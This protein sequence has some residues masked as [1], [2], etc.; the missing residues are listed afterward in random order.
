[1]GLLNTYDLLDTYE[2]P[3]VVEPP[4][5]GRY[6]TPLN[7]VDQHFILNK[8]WEPS[9]DFN[10]YFD[11]Q[12]VTTNTSGR[13]LGTIDNDN[14][15]QVFYDGGSNQLK[16][17]LRI[18]GVSTFASGPVIDAEN[19]RKFNR[20]WFYRRG[21]TFGL[22]VN[23]QT[24]NEVTREVT[25]QDFKFI[26]FN[27]SNT[28]FQG[29]VANIF[30]EDLS[31]SSKNVTLPLDEDFAKAGASV[32]NSIK[33]NHEFV[34]VSSEAN[35]YSPRS[36]STLSFVSG[37]VRSTAINQFTFGVA[38]ALTNLT[39]GQTYFLDA[40]VK[41][42]NPSALV[43]IRVSDAVN[44]D[45]DAAN[46]ENANG[47]VGFVHTFVATATT[48]Y[49]GSIVTGHNANDYIEIV[50][51]SVKEFS[52]GS[53]FATAQNITESIFY[54]D[55]LDNG[56]YLSP[57]FKDGLTAE[58]FGTNTINTVDTDNLIIQGDGNVFFG[59]R[60]INALDI[61]ETYK[62]KGI[63]NIT[64]GA[65]KIQTPSTNALFGIVSQS[66]NFEFTAVSDNTTL[67]FVRNTGGQEIDAQIS[68]F[69]IQ[70]ILEVAVQAEPNTAPTVTI[71]GATSGTYQQAITLTANV[72]DADV[73]DTHTYLWEIVSGSGTLPVDVNTQSIVVTGGNNQAVENTVVRATVD[74]G[75]GG[76]A[77]DEHTISFAEQPDT[78]I[79][80]IT[81]IG[82]ASITINENDTY[83][84][85]GATASDNRDG[86][87]TNNIVVVN[88]VDAS[89]PATYTITYNVSDAAG[90]A[91][92]EVTRTVIVQEVDTTAPIITVS[93][94]A[95][96]TIT[97]GDALPTFNASTDDG[98][99]I[100]VSYLNGIEPDVNTV[101]RYEIYYDS[102]DAA[103]NVATT[104]TRVIIVEAIV[105][106]NLVI[107][108]IDS[109]ISEVN[110]L[111][112]TFSSGAAPFSATYAGQALSIDSQDA[113]SATISALDLRAFGD[114]SLLYNTNY[115]LVFTD[116]NTQSV[117]TSIV[118]TPTNQ[119]TEINTNTFPTSSVL[120]GSN[121]Q[122]GDYFY[123]QWTQNGNNQPIPANGD[124]EG[125]DL[126]AGETHTL[127]AALYTGGVWTTPASFNITPTL[128]DQV[129]LCTQRLYLNAQQYLVK[130]KQMPYEFT[131]Q[132]ADKP[133]ATYRAE[134]VDGAPTLAQMEASNALTA[135]ADVTGLSTHNVSDI[136]T[137]TETS[138][139]FSNQD[140]VC[141]I[142][143]GDGEFINFSDYV[144]SLSDVGTDLALYNAVADDV[145]MTESEYNSYA[146]IYTNN[147]IITP[148]IDSDVF[149]LVLKPLKTEVYGID[150]SEWVGTQEILSFVA[151]S[152]NTDVATVVSTSMSGNILLVRVAGVAQGVASIEFNYSTVSRQ[153]CFTGRVCVED[154]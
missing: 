32:S 151:S 103:G 13:I 53:N 51:F 17:R 63:S 148:S 85:A 58:S 25:R 149:Q 107:G 31:D 129:S 34:D 68:N 143:F 47:S 33:N 140:D 154:C 111:S 38:Q 118:T 124:L 119:F 10:I 37:L 153:D 40:K 79:P 141:A 115:D 114:L 104:V 152:G 135:I 46:E 23:S 27:G 30:F 80:V 146:Y 28:Y 41:S 131:L 97:E 76:T 60:Y 121:A 82:S 6:F 67:I 74:D 147:S 123:A 12:T 55:D 89:I 15:V 126:P 2:T 71:T 120:S 84:D 65:V 69:T 49:V 113:T 8:V 99:A 57:D 36:G 11:F 78:T 83:N 20:G 109:A 134:M 96:T 102:T 24:P 108:T 9:G 66:E 54:K 22:A 150:V 72:T 43:R 77:T 52:A 95:E 86:D 132:Y 87:L 14:G 125:L 94:T 35:W 117:T 142:S 100:V 133:N 3:A 98:S 91:A 144:D 127:N 56:R 70:S 44:L 130:Q 73:S 136:I 50:N 45:F 16:M 5:E 116:A 7:G 110:G 139:T 75:N 90:N 122:A 93:G 88:P 112:V 105:L 29:K 1:M 26:G 48:M 18:A 106:P 21:N 62:I 145:I 81:L 39:V 92:V 4:V 101:G 64:A 61:G 42:N 128:P 59:F 138:I 137:A 19:S